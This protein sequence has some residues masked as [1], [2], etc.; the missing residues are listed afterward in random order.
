[1]SPDPLDHPGRRV[2]DQDPE[3]RPATVG[4]LEKLVQT[5]KTE[6]TATRRQLR[7]TRWTAAGLYAFAM[8]AY[9]GLGGYVL[10]EAA[11]R[12]DGQCRIFEKAELDAVQQLRQTYDFMVERKPTAEL[13][14]LALSGLLQAERTAV[15][16]DAPGYCDDE[17][18]GLDETP[19]FEPA[20]PKRPA[21]LDKRHPDLPD[22]PRPTV[23]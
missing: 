8:L 5:L 12:E 21:L 4:D 15:S 22:Q 10:H 20:V 16:E 6:L 11:V 19:E 9:A 7:R 17:G 2:E 23:P 13:Y 1:M 3:Q 14:D 18:V